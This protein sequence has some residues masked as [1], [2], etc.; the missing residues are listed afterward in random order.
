MD[1]GASACGRP[2]RQTISLRRRLTPRQPAGSRVL[3]LLW[4]AARE[5][6]RRPHEEDPA[7]RGSTPLPSDPIPVHLRVPAVADQVADVRHAVLE[8]ARA[9]GIGP[10]PRDDIALAVSE[11]CT[12]VVMH[13]YRDAA[14]PGPLAV[15]AYR[16]DGAFFVVVCDEGTGLSPRTDSPGL[17]LG[18]GL[19]GRLAQRLEISS[20]D[21]VGAK[22][23]MI[24]AAP[25]RGRTATCSDRERSRRRWTWTP[26]KRRLHPRHRPRQRRLLPRRRRAAE[27]H[28]PGRR[29]R[30][31]PR[32]PRRPQRRVHPDHVRRDRSV[33]GRSVP[34]AR[35]DQRRAP[36]ARRHEPSTS[37]H[38]LHHL[39]AA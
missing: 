38:C 2:T 9:C 12:N 31:R 39:P 7:A 10:A 29:R 17:G 36:R 35:L 14:A 34:T 15:D 26:E 6:P 3:G 22:L 19:I 11:A 18:L 16:D 23:T 28:R 32:P 20:H 1:K 30:R 24:F 5:G 37:H 33:F 27:Q 13:A 25:P 4:A 8:S 21:P